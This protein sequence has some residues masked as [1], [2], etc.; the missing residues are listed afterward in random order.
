M[1]E[2]YTPVLLL[3]E[4][5]VAG[6][7]CNLLVLADKNTRNNRDGQ[8]MILDTDHTG[9]LW[10]PE[11]YLTIASTISHGSGYFAIS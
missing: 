10:W 8:S 7:L 3:P 9:R 2:K 11:K 6:Y 4:P 1:Q 5:Y